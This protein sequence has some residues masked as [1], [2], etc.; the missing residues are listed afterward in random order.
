MAAIASNRLWRGEAAGILLDDNKRWR[1]R[2]AWLKENIDIV[3]ELHIVEAVGYLR[4]LA[5][6][7]FFWNSS[8][9]R[10]AQEAI[11]ALS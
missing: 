2:N 3:Q 7:P 1:R 6:K 5:H 8:L 4:R 9:R 10:R 11:E